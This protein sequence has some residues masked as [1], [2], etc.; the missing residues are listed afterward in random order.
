[1]SP[2]PAWPRIRNVFGGPGHWRHRRR[3]RFVLLFLLA[4]L[5]TLGLEALAEHAGWYVN[6]S[7]IGMLALVIKF[8]ELIFAKVPSAEGDHR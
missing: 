8:S 4:C 3:I 7:A 2:H 5:L 1:M 6:P